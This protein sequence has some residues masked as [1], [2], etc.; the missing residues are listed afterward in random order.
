VNQVTYTKKHLTLADYLQENPGDIESEDDVWFSI[1]NHY[2]WVMS[3]E[4]AWENLY[5]EINCMLNSEE[6]FFQLSHL[7]E[8]GL[9]LDKM[10]DFFL[11]DVLLGKMNWGKKIDGESLK[12]YID[13]ISDDHT[14][15]FGFTDYLFSTN[16]TGNILCSYKRN[17]FL[18]DFYI[19]YRN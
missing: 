6:Y 17:V 16:K 13:A 9:D 14:F 1:Y 8:S 7:E 12:R 10:K 18:N 2:Y 5:D 3:K 11:P 19:Y 4:E 15:S